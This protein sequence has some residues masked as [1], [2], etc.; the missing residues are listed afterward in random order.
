VPFNGSGSFTRVH[1]WETDRN[2][3]V[4]IEA[5]RM[6]DEDDGIATGLSNVICKDGQSTPTADIGFGGFKVRNV[7]DAANAT[8]AVNRQTGDA[9]YHPIGAT[10]TTDEA[11]AR[12]NGV[13]GSLQNSGV[14]IDDSNNLTVPATI[15]ALSTDTGASTFTGLDLYRNSATPAA[16]DFI[17]KAIFSG[18]DSGGT[19]TTYAEI[20]GQITDP[21]DTSEDGRVVVRT[22]AAGT[23]ADRVTVGPGVQL[24][25]PTNGD[26]GTGT[27][28]ATGVYVNDDAALTLVAVQTA[29]NKTFTAP[30]INTGDINGGTA[31]ALTSL[32]I[33]STGA[34]FD[35]RVASTEVLTDN[36]T[37]TI[38]LNDTNRTIDLG[39]NITL[40]SAFVTSGAN[41]LTLTTTGATNVTLPTSGTLAV[42]G[43]DNTFTA[44]QT[45]TSTDAGASTYTALVVDRNSATPANN[46]F[47]GKMIWTGRDNGAGLTTYA[48]IDAQITDTTNTSEDGRLI[49]RAMV[50]GVMTD[51]LT[52]DA[53]GVTLGGSATGTFTPTVTLVG[54]A[55][56]TVPVYSTNTGRYTRIGNR[57]WV[58]ILLTGDGGAEGAGTGAIN[59]ALPFAANTSFTL[60]PFLGGTVRNGGTEF[61]AAVEIPSAGAS[62][63]QV[64]Y[65]DAINN[66]TVLSGDLQNNATRLIRLAFNY[67]V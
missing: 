58:D 17:G 49:L 34:A 45:V 22:V 16:N 65:F 61:V 63:V 67:E 2:N 25:A 39:G 66:R 42:I 4:K 20:D 6:D 37:L 5:E 47:I 18:K 59:L 11:I 7:G 27:L 62:T 24:G 19:K 13:A 35:M 31:D 38:D 36:K 15:A 54:G 28:N 9:R 10:T 1:S 43:A 50:A 14:T 48:E 29:T 56:N 30:V 46:D 40:A 12:Y 41:S 52:L 23:L 64:Q 33:R 3:G 44:G 51:L 53:N 32:G 60:E 8:D 57:C 55:G 26:K 21:T